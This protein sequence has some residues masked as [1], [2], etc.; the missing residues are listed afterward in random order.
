[1]AGQRS[2]EE[3]MNDAQAKVVALFKRAGYIK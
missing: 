3:A 2:A 1:L